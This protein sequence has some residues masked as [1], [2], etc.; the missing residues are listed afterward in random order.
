MPLR[1]LIQKLIHMS[2][3]GAGSRYLRFLV[4]GLA[5]VGL[6]LVYNLRAYRNLATQEAMDS[7]QLARNIA[8]GKGYTT[9]FIRPFSLYLVQSHNQAKHAAA[10]ATTNLDF[11][12]I[13]FNPHPDLAN[14][15]V[16]P[17][18]LAGLMT[19]RS[20]RYPVEL[21]KPFWSDNSHF[22][23][24]Q[25]DFQIAVFNEVLLLVVVVLTFFLARKLFDVNVAW[26]AALLTI[27]CELLWQFSVSGLSTLLLMVIFLGLT[28]CVLRIEEMVRE[29]QPRPNWLLGLALASGVLTGVGA[30]T[31]YAFGW[32]IIPVALFLFFFSGQRRV[33]HTLA[34]LG[35]FV[36][37]LIPWVIRNY[38]VSGTPFGTAGFAIVEGTGLFPRFQLERSVHP[39]LTHAL[40]LKLYVTKLLGNAH[41][42]LVNELPR[43]GGSWASILFL[44]GLLLGFRGMAV[45]RMRYFLLMCL[46]TFIVVQ[47]LGQTQLSNESPAVNSEDLLVLLVPLVFCY[48]VSFFFTFL[49]QM[50]LPVL[51]LRYAV[52]AVFAAL[53]C[54]PMIFT[55]V[56]PKASP[57]VYPPYYPPD[58]QNTAGWMKENELM[59]SDVPWAVAWYGR[60]QCVWLTLNV[61]DDFFAINDY[62]KPV[63]ALYLTPG[64]MDGKFVSEL[65]RSGEHSWGSF[66]ALGVL[67]NQIPQGFPLRNA[68]T[69]FLPD[70]LF[71]TDRERWKTAP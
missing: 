2:E 36:V 50:K 54:L 70:R 6:A 9:L 14:P 47:A 63:Q 55:L 65:L 66:I 51:Q 31:R 33:L 30:L 40:W 7:A 20:F 45:R 35:A 52:I 3:V 12:Q 42:I 23:R 26:L 59:M 53:S 10:P 18:V 4:L 1:E 19:V 34:A 8:D 71:L 64:T 57:V 13:K 27:G 15:P 29:P 22:W 24:Y 69:G 68:P 60:H 62:L 37:V 48:G 39:D 25:P 56:S 38:A 58:I 61:Q 44:A 32:T 16:Y 21:M 41:D 67:Q 17:V 28:W 5:V 43:L 46:G 49:E 11:A